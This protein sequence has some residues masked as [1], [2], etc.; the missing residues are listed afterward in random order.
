MHRAFLIRRAARGEREGEW[1]MMTLQLISITRSSIKDPGRAL[2]RPQAPR[3]ST[4]RWKSVILSRS[5][6]EA[7]VKGSA[8]HLHPPGVIYRVCGKMN[9]RIKRASARSGRR[10]GWPR[11]RQWCLSTYR[12]T[13][14]KRAGYNNSREKPILSSRD[15]NGAQLSRRIVFVHL[16]TLRR[17]SGR[18]AETRKVSQPPSWPITEVTA[19][20]V[21]KHKPLAGCPPMSF[22]HRSS[23][24]R[25]ETNG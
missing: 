14:T 12:P 17:I 22:H 5:V 16:W 11:G 13:F 20:R 18:D 6:P 23:Y 25:D 10:S 15:T 4:A 7:L 9:G 1:A 19:D 3:C 21:L 8:L 24:K 2:P